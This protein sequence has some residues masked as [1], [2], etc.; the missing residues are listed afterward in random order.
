MAKQMCF[1]DRPVTKTAAHLWFDGMREM[2]SC[3]LES[4]S[5]I[6]HLKQETGV[7]VIHTD[8]EGWKPR[9]R[10]H[11]KEKEGGSK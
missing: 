11:K 3:D 1:G 5:V 8:D 4:R 10:H 7:D 2:V 6:A 9:I